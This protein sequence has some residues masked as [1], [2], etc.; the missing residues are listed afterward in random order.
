[1]SDIKFNCPQCGQHLAVDA[2]GAGMTVAC[3]KCGQATS[4][5]SAPASR[6]SVTP[7]SS[8]K[9]RWWLWPLV[10]AAALA[11]A[12][13][14]MWF[15]EFRQPETAVDHSSGGISEKL[16][17]KDGISPMTE[18]SQVKP[19]AATNSLP[20]KNAQL[21]QAATSIEGFALHKATYEGDFEEVKA[22]IAKGADVNAQGPRDTNFI[23]LFFAVSEGNVNFR[24]LFDTSGLVCPARRNEWG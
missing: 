12:I 24:E 4:V 22:L 21:I 9:T 23:P 14:A 8:V 20:S 3:P 19:D 16:R 11:V 13:I 18:R 7:N 2:A 1:M 6:V 17:A 15:L 5:P 10:G